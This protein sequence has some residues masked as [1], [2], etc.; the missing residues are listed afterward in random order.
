MCH[1][2]LRTAVAERGFSPESTKFKL[3]LSFERRTRNGP[4]FFP[5]FGAYYIQY[6]SFFSSFIDGEYLPKARTKNFRLRFL[7]QKHVCAL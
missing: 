1:V 3:G 4:E 7:V 2:T 5:F 6:Q